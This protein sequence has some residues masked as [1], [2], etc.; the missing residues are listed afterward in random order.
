[1]NIVLVDFIKSPLSSRVIESSL[2]LGAV[3]IGLINA[4]N[5]RP[6]DDKQEKELMRH[7]SRRVTQE[8]E[9]MEED[10]HGAEQTMDRLYGRPVMFEHGL[11]F[12]AG[13]FT[14]DALAW[15]MGGGLSLPIE[16][17]A[18]LYR[19][20]SREVL[21]AQ[22]GIGA[23]MTRNQVPANPRRVP[24]RQHQ[25]TQ[26]VT[27]VPVAEEE[28][29]NFDFGLK[30]GG[31]V[32][33]P[34][35]GPVGEDIVAANMFGNA[36]GAANAD[37][38]IL[39]RDD[40][41]LLLSYIWKQFPHDVLAQAPNKYSAAQGSYLLLDPVARGTATHAMLQKHDFTGMFTAI[42]ARPVSPNEWAGQIMTLY[43]PVKG[44][45]P[46]GRV[47]NFPRCLYYNKWMEMMN[48]VPLQ[49][50]ATVRRELY[51]QF[52]TLHWLPY[53]QSDRMW[54]TRQ[55]ATSSVWIGAQGNDEGGKTAPTIAIN[56]LHCRGINEIVLN[57][58]GAEEE[59]AVPEEEEEEGSDEDETVS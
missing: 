8:D 11:Y 30:L 58:V 48:R 14:S 1:M 20:G 4:L 17:L 25:M 22:F 41:D 3:I 33:D 51:K 47:Q 27:E 10:Q 49:Y 45:V 19:I 16:K 43:F 52:M 7:C 12:L 46:V 54:S 24:N 5:H 42:Q 29:V 37:G 9:E 50:E 6:S 28:E 44:H 18:S 53:A 31:V 13:V 39:P 23:V 2:S 59:Q 57:A 34:P 36:D 40:P 32:L 26:D 21:T 55:S 56:A 38:E 15:Q 35:V